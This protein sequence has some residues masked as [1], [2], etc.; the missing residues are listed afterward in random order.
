MTEQQLKGLGFEITKQYEH[1]QFHTNRYVKG[2]LEVEFT[3]EGDKLL[4]CDLTISEMNCK[5]VTLDEMKALT[6]ILGEW[7]E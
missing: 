6:P 2:V 3:Y 4:T 5:P 1:D 7:H